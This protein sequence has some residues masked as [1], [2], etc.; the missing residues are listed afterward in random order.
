MPDT[1]EQRAVEAVLGTAAVGRR[2][3]I[4][5]TIDPAAPCV[6]ALVARGWTPT[7][8]LVC[9]QFGWGVSGLSHPRGGPINP[10]D[11]RRLPGGSSS[12]CAVAVSAGLVD[13]AVG[14]DTGGSIR[15]PAAWCGVVGFRPSTG[16]VSTDGIAP[17]SPTFDTP[18]LMTRTVEDLLPAASAWGIDAARSGRR[19]RV[20]AARS[21]TPVSAAVRLGYDAALAR[22]VEAGVALADV[23]VDTRGLRRTF[24]TIQMAESV[25]SLAAVDPATFLPAVRAQ[26]DAALGVT[27]DDEAAARTQRAALRWPADVDVVVLPTVGAEPP[28]VDAPDTV[29]TDDGPLPVARSV[30]EPNVLAPL[31]G[32]PALTVPMAAGSTLGLQLVAPPGA[33][34]LL[35]GLLEPLASLLTDTTEI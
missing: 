28:L 14:T 2:L 6:R 30:V 3:G 10:L 16:R 24:S 18:G 7:H 9:D 21:A 34:E 35:L 20:G 26:H 4:K 27:A 25:R 1:I 33:D 22:L 32:A 12:G 5:A 29:A 31:F 19:I 13:T 23:E 15:I 11:P 8:V 17:L